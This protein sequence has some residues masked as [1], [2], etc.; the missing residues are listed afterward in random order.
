MRHLFARPDAR[1][2]PE[3]QSYPSEADIAWSVVQVL[4]ALASI[5]GVCLS[6]LKS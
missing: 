4:A 5:I 6:F 1:R 3:K 2:H